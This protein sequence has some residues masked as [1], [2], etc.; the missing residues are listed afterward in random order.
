M[1]GYL[2]SRA[3][4][5]RGEYR[6]ESGSGG[7]WTKEGLSCRKLEKTRTWTPVGCFQTLLSPQLS[8]KHQSMLKDITR[9]MWEVL[10]ASGVPWE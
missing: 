3:E 1:G 7:T 4:I 2:H 10:D 9:R 6:G 5:P 8:S